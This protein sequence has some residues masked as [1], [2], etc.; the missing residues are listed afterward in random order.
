MHPNDDDRTQFMPRPGGRAPEPARAEPAPLSMPA[1][2]ILTGK[3]QGL[4]P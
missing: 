3:S 4:N 1:A 2:P